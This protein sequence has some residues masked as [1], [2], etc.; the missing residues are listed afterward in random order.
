MTQ[1]A[2][3]RPVCRGE[4]VLLP[5]R[6]IRVV[7]DCG[8]QLFH[9]RSGFLQQCRLLSPTARQIQIALGNLHACRR[10]ALSV[11]PHF[12]WLGPQLPPKTT[13]HPHTHSDTGQDRKD[14]Q[15]NR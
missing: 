12:N 9:G 5:P 14:H 15:N 4:R 10:H 13:R 1:W 6:V 7:T 8:S 3:G 2:P 11:I